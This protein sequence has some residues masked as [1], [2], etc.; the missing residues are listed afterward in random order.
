MELISC[1]CAPFQGLRHVP[2]PAAEFLVQLTIGR[3]RGYLIGQRAPSTG[4]SIRMLA[5]DTPGSDVLIAQTYVVLGKVLAVPGT[6]DRFVFL[7]R[8]ANVT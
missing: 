5:I 2:S 6:T 8:R 7:G 4:P 3:P 1:R